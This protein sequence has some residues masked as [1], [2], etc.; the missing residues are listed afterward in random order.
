MKKCLFLYGDHNIENLFNS[1]PSKINFHG[2]WIALKNKLYDY[3]IDLKSKEFFTLRSPD[4]E[5]HINVWN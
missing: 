2:Q 4:L 3:G 1:H 5:I